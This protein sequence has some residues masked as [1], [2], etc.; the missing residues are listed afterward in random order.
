MTERK[1]AGINGSAAGPELN[2]DYASA[3][4]FDKLRVGSLGVYYRDGFRTR[5]IA[6]SEMER[7]FIRIQE[8]RGRMCCGQATFAYYRM[9]FVVNGKEY[10][11][12]ISESEKDMD[13]ALARIHACAPTLPI[14][15]RE[16]GKKT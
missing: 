14:G 9:V 4:V 12:Y 6:Y 8:V 2:A 11:D 10:Q 5:F 15:V 3:A 1:F 7:A 16:K 13:A